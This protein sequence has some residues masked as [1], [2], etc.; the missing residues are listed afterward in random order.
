M[1]TP[2]SNH[3]VIIYDIASENIYGLFLRINLWTT[4]RGKPYINL[5]SEE[6]E[7]QERERKRERKPVECERCKKI[8]ASGYSMRRHNCRIPIEC[9]RCKGL[10]ASVYSMRRHYCCVH[11]KV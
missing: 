10:Y 9:E 1:K 6:Q 7:R 3:P 4:L 2:Y 8:Y 11:G 5:M